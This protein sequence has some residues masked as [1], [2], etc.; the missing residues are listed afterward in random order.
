MRTGQ[1]RTRAKERPRQE[2]DRSAPALSVDKAFVLQL[3]GE[4]GPTLDPCAGRLEHLSTG[5]RVRF[6]TFEEFRAALTRLL[7]E[8]GSR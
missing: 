1:A 8:V 6:E 3:R 2:P 5:R 7:E 4:T